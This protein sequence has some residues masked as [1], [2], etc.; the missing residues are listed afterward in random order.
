MGCVSGM[1]AYSLYTVPYEGAKL[2]YS[3]SW[4]YVLGT[5]EGQQ[6]IVVAIE[7]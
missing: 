6:T 4:F 1:K 2:L 3:P 7:L 5:I